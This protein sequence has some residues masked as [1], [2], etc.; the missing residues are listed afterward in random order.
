MSH[1][2]SCSPEWHTAMCRRRFCSFFNDAL[3][4]EQYTGPFPLAA[5][6]ARA[7]CRFKDPTSPNS[8]PQLS[9]ATRFSIVPWMKTVELSGRPSGPSR[10]PFR[11]PTIP[12]A[13]RF[14]PDP[15]S[16]PPVAS[17]P[18]APGPPFA[19]AMPLCSIFSPFMSYPIL[20][21]T[22]A[23]ASLLNPCCTS[24]AACVTPSFACIDLARA[25]LIPS[26]GCPI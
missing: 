3:H 24:L 18:S 20:G 1:R 2:F 15:S 23:L 7:A 4:C 11:D 6:C 13:A 21:P 19:V 22:S 14:I 26:C 16:P 10:G 8:S 17:I 25:S 9:H 12:P 5:R